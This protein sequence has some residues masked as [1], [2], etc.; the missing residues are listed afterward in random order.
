MPDTSALL[1]FCAASLALLLTPGPAVLYIVTRGVAQGRGAAIVSV[2][3]VHTGSAVHVAA[4]AFGI[5]ALLAASAT[6][7]TVIK[8]VGAAYLIWL[9]VR[10][11]LGRSGG[12]WTAEVSAASPGRLFWE[13][14]VVN[15]LNPKTA[16]FFPAF[17]PQFVDHRAG[18]VAAQVVLLGLIWIVL[19]LAGDGCF[20]LASAAPADRLRRSV[21][22]RRGLDVGS[23]AI[24]VGM[25]A[26]AA[27]SGDGRST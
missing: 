20:A 4:A 22:V 21:K 19:G 17:L 26:M 9:G 7:F 24:F 3:G 2:L 1:V 12:S 23:G 16:M 10:K 5:T 15:V 25:G 6:A 14:F 18:P 27:L 11:L 13:G 8:Y